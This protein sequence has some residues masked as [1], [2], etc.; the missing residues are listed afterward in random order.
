MKTHFSKILTTFIFCLFVVITTSPITIF[1]TEVS[2]PVLTEEINIYD[3]ESLQTHLQDE[4][5]DIV[6]WRDITISE[7]VA[8]VCNSIDLNGYNLTFSTLILSSSGKDFSILDRTYNEKDGSSSGKLEIKNGLTIGDSTCIIQSGIVKVTNGI[9]GTGDVKIYNG[10]VTVHGKKGVD[11][12]D[13]TLGTDGED[14]DR[15]GNYYGTRGSNGGNGADGTSGGHG[16]EASNVYIYGGTVSVIG[17]RG[18]N[19]GDGGAGGRG[20]NNLDGTHGKGQSGSDGGDGGNAGKSGAGIVAVG[21]VVI[22]GGAV[23]VTGGDGA[24]GGAGG[25]GGAG[26]TGASANSGESLYQGGAGGD[27]G[28]GGRGGSNSVGSEAILANN[29]FVY[30]GE[31]TTKGGSGG[32]EGLGGIGGSGGAGG[33]KWS[34]TRHPD[35]TKGQNGVDGAFYGLGGSGINANFMMYDGTV[36]ATG[37]YGAAGIG[38]SGYSNEINGHDVNIAGGNVIVSGIGSFDIGG[39][40]NGTT[41]GKS[42]TLTVTGG[43]IEFCSE[44]RATNVS[45][46]TFENCTVKGKGADQHEGTYDANGKFTVSIESIGVL[47]EICVGYDK[48]ALQATISVSRTSNIS[49]PS[50][51]GYISFKLDGKEIG[52]ATIS[53]PIVSDGK[54]IAS[55]IIDW[56]AVEGEHILTAEYI[57]GTGDKYASAG[58]FEFSSNITP[59]SHNWEIDFTVDIESTCITEGS[60]S[61]HCS[62]CNVQKDITVVPTIGH[63]YVNNQ[64]EMCKEFLPLVVFKDYDGTILSSAYYNIGDVI[65]VPSD[66]TRAADKTYTYSFAGWDKSIGACSGNETFTATY[67]STFIEYKVVF[68]NHD[69]TVVSEESYHYD[70][71]VAEPSDI[72]TKSSDNIYTY[73]FSGW[74]NTVTA[75]KGDTVYTATFTPAYINYTITFKNDNGTILDSKTYHYGDTIVQPNTPTKAPDNVYSYTFKSW[76]KD[77]VKCAGDVTYTATY[78]PAYIDYTV[79]FVDED[80]TVLSTRTYHYG[81]TVVAP[82]TPTKVSTNIYSYIF[83]GWDKSVTNCD[84]NAT[85]KATYNAEYINYTV[86]FKNYNGDVISTKTYHYGDTVEEPTA[87][88]KPSDS[89]YYYE[90]NGWDKTVSACSG[91]AEYTAT[92]TPKK[93]P[94]VVV[95]NSSARADETVIVDIVLSGAPNLESLAISDIVY[96]TT[97]LELVN[98]EWK[99]E[100]AILSNWDVSTGKGALAYSSATNLNGTIISLTFKV[101]ASAVDGD[102]SISCVVISHECDFKNVAGKIT[103]CSVAPGDVDGNESIDKD[104]AIYLLMHSFF[105]EDYPVNQ[106]ADYT[107]D[108]EVNK[109]DAIHLLMHTFFPDDYPLALPPTATTSVV[110]TE[111]RKKEDEE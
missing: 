22:Y 32:T 99:T 13:G 95:N 64:C 80:N 67:A 12:R 96:D 83:A 16:I 89:N 26:A 63:N 75:C 91:N 11:G 85:Y 76:D 50:P 93:L 23:T 29:V 33:R 40:Y 7:P 102:Y 46:P 15:Y 111:E 106:E 107:G 48:V 104:D 84:G 79:V 20:G 5:A 38:G 52:N 47:P 4:N 100:G 1:A 25:R 56:V 54:I 42:G 6:L 90:F 57:A 53:N 60:K 21:D 2:E 78:T 43:N 41:T 86:V 73:T 8:A 58:V 35:G 19:G 17:G 92:F 31:I 108:G 34:G 69:G 14:G 82:A 65:V 51:R 62:I 74:D 66:P 36:V 9:S 103:V 59:H 71:V 18:G 61:I 105:P 49:T 24:S 88:Q 110:A 30:S 81:D 77:V 45:N 94:Q 39:G 28:A 97:V 101:K 37:G 55:A 98:F 10:I 109:D 70:A 87:P 44:G 72:P 3:S 27:G 68:K